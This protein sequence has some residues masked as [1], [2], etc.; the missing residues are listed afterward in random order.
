MKNV[1]QINEIYSRYDTYSEKSLSGRII[2]VENIMPLLKEFSAKHLFEVKVIGNSVKGKPVHSIKFGHGKTKVLMW[3][4]MHGDEPTATKAVFD[5]LNFLSAADDFENLRKT[6]FKNL[7]VQIIPMLNP[8]GAEIFTRENALNIDINRDAKRLQSPEAKILWDIREKFNPDFGFNLHDQNNRYSAGKTFKSAVISMLAPP[9]NKKKT[10]D[11]TRKKAMQII[12]DIRRELKKFVPGHIARYNDDF[13][14]RAF[15]DNFMRR[16][17]STILIESGG[18]K[19]D[20]DK[21]F[22]RKMNFLAFI[23]ALSSIASKSYKESRF[24]EYYR[25]PENEKILFDVLLRNLIRKINGCEHIV[26]IGINRTEQ[27]DENGRIFYKG[28][29]GDLGDLS[30]FF[31]YEEYDLEGFEIKKAEYFSE[32]FRNIENIEIKNIDRELQ[33]G[34]MIIL[35]NEKIP[36]DRPFELPILVINENDNFDNLIKT[37]CPAFFSICKDNKNNYSV[38]NGFFRDNFITSSQ[39]TNGIVMKL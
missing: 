35:V 19:D 14:P 20:D 34:K 2:K 1:L 15:G 31:G 16:G 22:V 12:V 38:V 3:T 10:V 13:E 17:T 9:Y 18:W 26:D 21:E 11:K 6:I 24:K 27:V 23:S 25:I 4:Q 8:D 32:K 33:N 28:T 30:T 37:D 5:L 7:T 29:I 39:K 36:R